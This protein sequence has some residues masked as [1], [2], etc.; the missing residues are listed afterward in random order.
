LLD[1]ATVH[2]ILY[3]LVAVFRV[4]ELEKA[5]R[6]RSRDIE[7]VKEEVNAAEASLTKFCRFLQA[8]VTA[9]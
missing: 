1:Y 7:L 6:D 5:V 2:Y 8:C 3:S 9:S 4:A